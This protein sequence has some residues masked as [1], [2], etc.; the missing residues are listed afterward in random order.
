MLKI[1]PV[2]YGD[3]AEPSNVAAGGTACQLRY[4]CAGCGFFRPNPSHIPEI[5]KEVLKLR[6]QL[7][8]AETSDTAVYL[9][10]AQRGLIA[11]YEKVLETMRA[12]LEEM[13]PEQRLEIETMSEVSR[14]ARSAALAGKHI[15]L[16]E[17]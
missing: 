13:S 16:R 14:R 7:R 6:S 8:I 4:Q 3:C 12:R 5:E 11:D 15:E 2:P 10:D 9:L 17:I 1:T